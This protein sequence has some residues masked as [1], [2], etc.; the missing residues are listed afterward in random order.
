VKA[1]QVFDRLLLLQ[2]RL[3]RT[4]PEESPQIYEE[5][6]E[7]MEEFLSLTNLTRDQVEDA[8]NREYEKFVRSQENDKN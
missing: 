4:P 6:D 8:L 3:D 7:A 1:R 5:F 2:Y